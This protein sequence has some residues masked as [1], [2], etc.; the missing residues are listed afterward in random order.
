MK[1][2]I[3]A[4]ES[5]R[6]KELLKEHGFQ[7][8]VI[9]SDIEEVFDLKLSPE[10]NT[11]KIAREKAQAVALKAKGVILS[12]DTMV[13]LN[14]H[15]L[16]KPKNKTHAK[17]MLKLLSGKAH[18]VITAFVI[19]DTEIK[20]EYSKIVITKVTFKKLLPQDIEKYVETNSPYDKAGSYAVQ[21][22]GDKF[23]EK[24]NGSLTNIIGLPLDEVIEGLKK[25]GILPSSPH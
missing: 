18:R 24:I 14:H 16:G 8:E 10:E 15:L 2:L 17:K 12:A 7:F 20:K 3:L 11:L 4:S 1:K 5:Q 21:E 25:Y 19:Y 23:I 9:P 6:R 22:I 13:V